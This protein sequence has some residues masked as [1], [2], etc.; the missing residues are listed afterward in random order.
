VAP[1]HLD[2]DDLADI[3]RLCRALVENSAPWEHPLSD[4]RSALVEAYN[5]Y[6]D[7]LAQDTIPASQPPGREK[8]A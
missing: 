8:K 7:L 1:E 3:G 6:R 4:R 2:I 5:G